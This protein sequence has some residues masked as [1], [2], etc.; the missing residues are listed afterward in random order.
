M[1]SVPADTGIGAQHLV[2]VPLWNRL[3]LVL[4][5]ELLDGST[6]G[7]S[8]E[9]ELIESAHPIG[10]RIRSGAGLCL[11]E[12]VDRKRRRDDGDDNRKRPGL[13][14]DPPLQRRYGKGTNRKG[15]KTL[16]SYIEFARQVTSSQRLP[17]SSRQ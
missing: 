16:C 11:R 5:D 9:T 7:K 15:G 3:Q 12:I 8:L 6:V 13:H 2:H 17:P 14:A 1:P 4:R 10:N